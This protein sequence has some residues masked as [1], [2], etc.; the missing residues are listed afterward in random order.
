MRISMIV[1]CIGILTLLTI[2]QDQQPK[3]VHFKKLQEFLPSQQIEGFKR[4]KPI[5]STQKTMGLSASEAS[6]R[7]E[8]IDDEAG[9]NIEVKIVD[10]SLIPFAAWAM[11][12]QQMEYEN[13]TE[14]GYEKSVTVA[15]EYKGLEQVSNGE[16]KSCSLNFAV[17]NRY[18]VEI[19]AYG[20]DDIKILYTLVESMKL[21]TLAKLTAE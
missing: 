13:E 18:H 11:A 15:K 14:E 9:Q 6:V 12:Y 20:F 21:D 4:T 2:A 5:G 3:I 7:Y 10:M 17:G 1:V 8:K 19:D 16:S